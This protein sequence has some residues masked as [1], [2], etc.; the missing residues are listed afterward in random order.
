VVLQGKKHM[1]QLCT[2]AAVPLA[3]EAA[4]SGLL[5][6]LCNAADAGASRS[7]HLLLL[8]PALPP[9]QSMLNR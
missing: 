7:L 1:Q 8:L 5:A 9:Q 2:C 6:L 4:A 3:S